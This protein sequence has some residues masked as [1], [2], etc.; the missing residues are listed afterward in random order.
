MLNPDAIG[1][2][3][4]FALT[5]IIFS[6]LIKDNF[7]YRLAVHALTGLAAGYAFLVIYKSVIEKML[8]F[9]LLEDPQANAGLL[10]PLALGLLLLTKLLPRAG[11]AGN[12]SLA[13]LFGVGAALAVGG[14]IAGTLWPQVQASILSFNPVH[15]GPVKALNNFIIFAGTV[16]ALFYFY[17][18]GTRRRSA[19]KAWASVGRAFIMI[20][21]GAL[22]A[23]GLVTF[24]TL[25]ISRVKFLLEVV[26]W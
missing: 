17:F 24:L 21:L 6:Y 12:I 7:L 18:T 8:L 14:A 1:Q 15:A 20:A 5:L 16:S 2:W 9:P 4:A 13:F 3:I 22:F 10:V 23:T 19:L 26:G 25:L 11:W